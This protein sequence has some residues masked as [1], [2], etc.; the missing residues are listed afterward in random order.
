[1]KLLLLRLFWDAKVSG[2]PRLL[3]CIR[4]ITLNW[5]TD[6]RI[7]TQHQF[8]DYDLEPLFVMNSHLDIRIQT[9]DQFEDYDVKPLG[10]DLTSEFARNRPA[11]WNFIKT[12]VVGMDSKH[13]S[14]WYNELESDFDAGLA[15]LLAAS[16]NLSHIYF[17]HSN[18]FAETFQHTYRFMQFSTTATYSHQQRLLPRLRHFEIKGGRRLMK[19]PSAIHIHPSTQVLRLDMLNIKELALSRHDNTTTPPSLRRLEL[20][21]VNIEKDLLETLL[22]SDICSNLR[23]LRLDTLW[24]NYAAIPKQQWKTYSYAL[25]TNILKEH[26]PHLEEFSLTQNF[27][28]HK[29]RNHQILGSLSSL[30]TLKRLR[31]DFPILT[32]LPLVHLS[33]LL[34]PHLESL[35]LTDIP[36][37]DIG[38]FLIPEV[39]YP[40][41]TGNL[42][43]RP[44]KELFLYT[45]V[46]D[47]DMREHLNV[48]ECLQ[49]RS[50]KW[51]KHGL[52]FR[53]YRTADAKEVQLV[54]EPGCR[55]FRTGEYL[56]GIR[57]RTIKWEN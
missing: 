12:K 18:D 38:T 53:V 9:E 49:R 48:L 34:P 55:A 30:T 32:H 10:Q 8:E 56:R 43:K 5:P 24:L 40:Y 21:S 13:T 16:P 41:R 19:V 11:I 29:Y 26:Q 23:I 4:S 50:D 22:Q 15:F 6:I 17:D 1:M 51:I 45:K 2:R 28:K 52:D 35:H 57:K 7:Q 42:R 44:L 14:K 46:N 25:L 47:F 54:V 31:V 37:C 33:S 3:K 39:L 20:S 27:S 36:F